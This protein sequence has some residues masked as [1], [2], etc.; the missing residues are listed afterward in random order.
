[1]GEGGVCSAKPCRELGGLQRQA[2]VLAVCHSEAVN[3]RVGLVGPAGEFERLGLD[4]RQ[5][6]IAWRGAYCFLNF[7]QR[8]G[9]IAA[10][11]LARLREELASVPWTVTHA[12]LTCAAVPTS[13]IH[14]IVNGSGVYTEAICSSSIH[15]AQS[16]QVLRQTTAII[17]R[18]TAPPA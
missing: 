12:D 1:V 8:S 5:A 15:D 10:P 17:G 2:G 13:F 4:D 9:C 11:E 16:Q 6:Q 18:L 14:Y 7:L 3:E